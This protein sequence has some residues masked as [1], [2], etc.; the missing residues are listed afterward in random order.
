LIVGYYA[1]YQDKRNV[2][3]LLEYINGVEMFEAIR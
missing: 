2:C 1:A 3:F